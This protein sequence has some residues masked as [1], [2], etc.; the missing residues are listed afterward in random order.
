[1]MQAGVWLILSDQNKPLSQ[2]KAN[3]V[4]EVGG[5]E[6]EILPFTQIWVS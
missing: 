2:K 3:T 6:C 1:M 5:G 4:T